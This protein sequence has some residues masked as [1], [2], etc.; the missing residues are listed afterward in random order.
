MVQIITGSILVVFG[1]YIFARYPM[2]RDTKSLVLGALFVV[3][4]L[5]LKRVSLMIPLFGVPALKIGFE[6]LPMMLA[7]MLL[8][9]SYGFVVGLSVDLVG[10]MIVPT[11]FP[12]FGF[13]LNSVLITCLPGIIFAKAKYIEKK[14]LEAMVTI[15]IAV[16]ICVISVY[17]ISLDNVVISGNVMQ[18]KWIY[19]A[20]IIGI[21]SILYIVLWLAIRHMKKRVPSENVQIFY[22]WILAVCVTEI[23][24]SFLLT[25]YWLQGM[26]GIPFLVSLFIRVIKQCI[27]IPFDII[28][29]YQLLKV[30]KK[31]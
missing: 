11:G 26:Y 10:L 28:V 31:F 25:P 19:K 2:K 4:T 14:Q 1:V 29:G 24:V 20:M 17:V 27:M 7:S 8:S 5:V 30:L 15:T 9:P 18:I 3:I 21:C 16:V 23:S 12:F 13:T 22:I 6:M